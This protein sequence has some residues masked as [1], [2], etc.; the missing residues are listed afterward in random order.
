MHQLASLLKPDDFVFERLNLLPLLLRWIVLKAI[1]II[2]LAVSDPS[3]A[4]VYVTFQIP[5]LE[6]ESSVLVCRA[7]YGLQESC[8][9]VC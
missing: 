9:L 1:E 3:D 2:I 7:L 8:T 4:K 5:T 6:R